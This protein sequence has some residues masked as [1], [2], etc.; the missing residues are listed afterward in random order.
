MNKLKFALEMIRDVVVVMAFFLYLIVSMIWC[1]LCR[2]LHNDD[3][4][5]I[6]ETLNKDD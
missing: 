6:V 1:A 3:D 4:V 5:E 2:V